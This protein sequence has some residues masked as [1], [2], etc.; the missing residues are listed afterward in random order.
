VEHEA[1]GQRETGVKTVKLQMAGRLDAMPE[2]ADDP[3]RIGPA[4][5]RGGARALRWARLYSVPFVH[6]PS[7]CPFD[8]P[9]ALFGDDYHPAREDT[10][11]SYCGARCPLAEGAGRPCLERYRGRPIGG[12][13][14]EAVAHATAAAPIEAGEA[15]RRM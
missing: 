2:Q 3:L 6:C 7:L 1:D 4:A 10:V 9:V 11:W 12:G 8:P 15:A 5:T 14:D 13:A